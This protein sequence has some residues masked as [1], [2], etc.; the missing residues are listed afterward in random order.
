[1]DITSPDQL[2]QLKVDIEKDMSPMEIVVNNAA[3]VPML[4][5]R[6]GTEND[7]ERI[8]KVNVTSHI[9]VNCNLS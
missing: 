9:L 7:I 8:I 1:M 4:S 5:L 6:E 3:I 2:Q